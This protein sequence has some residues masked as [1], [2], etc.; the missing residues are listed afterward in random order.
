MRSRDLF[1]H[2][3]VVLEYRPVISSRRVAWHWVLLSHP[4]GTRA[5]ACGSAEDKGLASIA[6]RMKARHLK[7]K[8]VKVV[9]RQRPMQ[10]QAAEVCS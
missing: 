10:P 8:I 2:G 6:A 3:D 5:L 7:K 9:T 1:N 4:S